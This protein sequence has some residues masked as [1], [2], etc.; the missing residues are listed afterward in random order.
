MFFAAMTMYIIA[1]ICIFKMFWYGYK[2]QEKTADRY[3]A[4]GVLISMGATAAIL[5]DVGGI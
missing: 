3:G 5:L 2:G 1:L 4:I